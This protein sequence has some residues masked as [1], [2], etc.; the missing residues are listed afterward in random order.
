MGN[1]VTSVAEPRVASSEGPHFADHLQIAS[2]TSK[3]V[4]SRARSRQWF[5]A[6]GL[7]LG[8]ILAFAASAVLGAAV[9][10]FISSVL[11]KTPY[12][13]FDDP[14]LVEQQLVFACVTVGL[15]VWFARGGHYSER[16]PFRSDLGDI[17]AAS[18]VGL[19]INGFIEFAN[20]A[21]FSRLWIVMAWGLAAVLLP[22]FRILSRRVLGASGFW[23]VNGVVVGRGTHSEAVKSS[24]SKDKYLGYHVVPDG[25]LATLAGRTDRAMNARI[26]TL[27]R[28]SD[29]HTVILAPSDEE[30]QYLAPV[31]NSLNVHMI[32]YKI[33]PPI[34][35]LPL[36][37]LTTQSFLSCDAVLLTVRVGL[38]SP[39]AQAIKRLFDI[40]AA[41]ALLLMLAPTFV[42]LTL[43]VAADGGSIFFAHKRVGRHGKEFDCL[44]FRT[45]VPNAA[46]SLD[47]LLA[48][49][50]EVRREWMKTR[51]LRNDPRTTKLGA[52]LRL[53]SIDELPQLINV[54]RGDMSLVGPR[55]VTAQELN[56]HYKSDHSYYLL[57]RPGI[58]GLWQISG[59]ND[60]GYD[61]RVHMDAWYVRNWSLWSD[62]I[63]LARTLPV[64]ISRRGAY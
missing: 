59:R 13:A 22:T 39:L 63:I 18:C 14:R 46:A 49:N 58:T 35:R 31:I 53:A 27:L 11:L 28:D 60:I 57:V 10:Y 25:A 54:L 62:I 2:S 36:T 33:V 44:K 23:I 16:R 8:D 45:M 48:C 51:K 20:K 64:V 50:A 34:D 32:P 24:L 29:A 7:L 42:L 1:A 61:T 55:P 12:A 41:S 30:M 9:A 43:A 38:S 6:A 21:S 3:R 19:L 17:L 4:A 15:C 26:E 37:G 52:F 40:V 5:N 47:N 56:D